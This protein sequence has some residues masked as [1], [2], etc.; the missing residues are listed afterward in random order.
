MPLYIMSEWKPETANLMDVFTKITGFLVC[1]RGDV[2]NGLFGLQPV[3][4]ERFECDM[5][6]EIFKERK[7]NLKNKNVATDRH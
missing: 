6:R 7:E 3:L 4:L 5:W 1:R 2:R